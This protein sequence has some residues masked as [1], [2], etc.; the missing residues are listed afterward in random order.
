MWIAWFLV[1]WTTFMSLLILLTVHEN[2]EEAR[3]LALINDTLCSTLDVYPEAAGA[4]EWARGW[5]TQPGSSTGV[6]TEKVLTW[7]G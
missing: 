2:R 5:Q 1:T 7:V 6:E 3:L 4:D